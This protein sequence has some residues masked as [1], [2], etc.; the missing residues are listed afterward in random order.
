MSAV[1]HVQGA[2]N[3][4]CFNTS[5]EKI[6]Q[7]KFCGRC[8]AVTYCS[9]EC[10]KKDWALHKKLCKKVFKEEKNE[11]FSRVVALAKTPTTKGTRCRF[12][13]ENSMD[14]RVPWVLSDESLKECIQEGFVYPSPYPKEVVPK[15]I[16]MNSFKMDSGKTISQSISLIHCADKIEYVAGEKIEI[17]Q[18]AI[19][20]AEH[21]SLKAPVVRILDDPL[22][23]IRTTVYP[24]TSLT[25]HADQLIIDGACNSIS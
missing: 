21:I 1:S 2:S 15:I 23:S 20:K 22:F 12:T 4:K 13:F 9:P 25:I 8:K 16:V 10:Q 19:V 17:F 6:G 18:G 24:K 3:A 5:C 14:A 7:W 11:V